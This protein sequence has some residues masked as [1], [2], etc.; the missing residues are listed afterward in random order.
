VEKILGYTQEELQEMHLSQ[1]GNFDDTFS[2]W[3]RKNM[4]G[5]LL[6]DGVYK[7]FEALWKRKDGK[8]ISFELNAALL[9]NREGDV[10]GRVISARD[11]SERKKIQE[12]EMKNAFIANISHEFRTPLTLSIG[13]LEGL[14]RGE[15][16]SIGTGAKDQIGL[17]LRNNRRQLKL[18]NQLLEFTRLGSKSDEVSYYKK[19]LNLFVSALVDSFAFL[20]IKKDINLAFIPDE[21]IEAA[22]IDPGKLERVLLNIIGNA[23]KFT[24][25]GGSITITTKNGKENVEEKFIKISV[26]DTGI[27]IKEEDLPHIFERF[28]QIGSNPSRRGEGSGIGLSLAKELIE[29]QKG[30]IETESTYGG[31][32]TFTIYLPLGKDHI[33]DQDQINCER[34]EIMLSEK[35]I[36]LSD[37]GYEEDGMREE[38]PTG[39]RPLILFIDDNPDVRRYVT[40]ILSKEYEVIT[41]EDGLNGLEKLKDYMPDVIISDIM[42]LGWMAMNSVK[43]LNRMRHSDIFPLFSSL[44]RQIQHLK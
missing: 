26:H 37:L 5:K 8:L 30:K 9:R 27:G 41:A 7:E 21:A 4:V 18:I 44:P 6:E 43:R 25:R 16:G 15:Y 31:G 42:M 38:K 23:F 34:D 28:Q 3:L 19:D 20:A 17:A 1:L 14:L 35:E 22:Y 29:L 39:A 33:R 10:I 36:E 11:I 13:P 2:L 24:P 40:G 32:S 12:M